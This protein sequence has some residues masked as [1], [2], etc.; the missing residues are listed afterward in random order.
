MIPAHPATL[1]PLQADAHKS[2]LA[3]L[4]SGR[5]IGEPTLSIYTLSCLITIRKDRMRPSEDDILRAL[6]PLLAAGVVVE[7]KEPPTKFD[8][9]FRAG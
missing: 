6:A 8:R 3:A 9:Y 1:A 5:E 4:Q 7:V 2:I